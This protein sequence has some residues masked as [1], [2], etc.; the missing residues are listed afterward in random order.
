[1]AHKGAVVF[2]LLD[3]LCCRPA[4]ILVRQEVYEHKDRAVI[5][6]RGEGTPRRGSHRCVALHQATGEVGHN[7]FVAP[8]PKLTHGVSPGDTIVARQLVDEV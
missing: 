6:Q 8:Y 7:L 2:E 1:M 4:D 5:A 3:G